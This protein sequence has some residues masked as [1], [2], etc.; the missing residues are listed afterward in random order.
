MTSI[1]CCG[2][3]AFDAGVMDGTFDPNLEHELV[4][5]GLLEIGLRYRTL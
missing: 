5:P 1:G 2:D 3:R 4:S